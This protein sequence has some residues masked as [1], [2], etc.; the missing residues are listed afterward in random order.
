[1]N[2]DATACY[3]RIVPC[4][5]NLASRKFGVPPTVAQQM[6]VATIEKMFYRLRTGL[7]ISTSGYSHC[8]EHPIYGMGQ[9]AGNTSQLWGFLSSVL[10]QGYDE[11]TQGAQ[12]EFPDRSGRVSIHMV[13]FV[14]DNNAQHNQFLKDHPVSVDDLAEQVTPDINTWKTLLRASGGGLE[15]TK[16]NYQVME[17]GFTV[18]GCPILKGGKTWSGRFH[19]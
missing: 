19:Q 10:F 14:D 8:E 3:G 15:L 9:G 11:Q 4:L 18:A 16:C 5:A 12:Y 2:F 17:W 6:N 1:M 7:G 13:G